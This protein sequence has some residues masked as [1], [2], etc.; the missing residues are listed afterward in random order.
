MLPNQKPPQ[1]SKYLSEFSV[2]HLHV[3][4]QLVVMFKALWHMGCLE[5]LCLSHTFVLLLLKKD[6][7]EKNRILSVKGSPL[8][9]LI[10]V[11][12]VCQESCLSLR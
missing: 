5:L 11:I 3:S 8:T 1:I 10:A 4:G 6:A 9:V 7:V 12:S 2:Y